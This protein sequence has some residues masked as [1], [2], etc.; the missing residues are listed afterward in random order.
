MSDNYGRAIWSHCGPLKQKIEATFLSGSI[1]LHRGLGFQEEGRLRR[2]GY[3]QG[4]H[5][6][7]LLLGMTHEEFAA[8]HV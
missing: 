6:D 7:W 4:R 1:E 2:M 3:T 5:Y 8:A